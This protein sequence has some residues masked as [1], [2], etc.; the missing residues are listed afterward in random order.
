[1]RDLYALPAFWEDEITIR[2]RVMGT[3]KSATV[4]PR[5]YG[6]AA[7]NI[8]ILAGALV[9][10]VDNHGLSQRTAEGYASAVRS[11]GRFLA[12]HRKARNLLLGV[13]NGAFEKCHFA[14]E[15]EMTAQNP[16]SSVAARY[17]GRILGLLRYIDSEFMPLGKSLLERAQSG[18]NVDRKP[19]KPRQEFTNADRLA[20]RDAARDQV[21]AMEARLADGKRLLT[22]ANQGRLE[23]P[24]QIGQLLLN[25]C[26]GELKIQDL[27]QLA[28]PDS[29]T[30]PK[31]IRVRPATSF[32][33]IGLLRNLLDLM[34]PTPDDL[35]AFEVL[36][37]FET[38]WAP[39]ELRGVRISEFE[40]SPEG[41]IYLKHKPRARK[42]SHQLIANTGGS[43][44]TNALINRW[45]SATE[46]ARR[47]CS[48]GAED[49]LFVL[50][51]YN[52]DERG[53]IVDRPPTASYNLRKWIALHGLDVSEPHHIGRIRKT[54]KL[55]QA[56]RAGTLAGAAADDHHIEVFKGHYLPTTTIY[57]LTPAILRKATDKLFVRMTEP[58]SRG[59]VVVTAPSAMAA[60]DDSLPIEIQKA[61]ETTATEAAPDRVM[62]PVSCKNILDS[63]FSGPGTLCPERIRQCFSCSNSIVFE[64]HLPRVISL[65]ERLEA[66]RAELPPP[67]FISD[68]GQLYAN[69][70]SVLDSFPDSVVAAA[71][72][73][74]STEGLNLPLNMRIDFA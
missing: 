16:E 57:A 3:F 46:M 50:G 60:A 47:Q 23:A 69:V 65:S 45:L 44:N 42:S 14:W 32:R 72:Q 35:V 53:W 1:M 54:A 52:R 26:S 62:L 17:S 6:T 68:Y 71:R 73:R 58:N 34:S 2:G 51:R 18:P 36:L 11:L 55:I 22:A 31:S 4:R 8:R 43:W 29:L 13:D 20:L 7:L 74:V 41:R 24:G 59:P 64:D 49:F 61:A 33:A 70:Q 12:S 19:S 37:L 48:D 39:E 28:E 10:M 30:W 15:Q 40:D 67:Q 56:L 63:P 5:D 21:R 25:L 27:S 66:V 38:G 9:D